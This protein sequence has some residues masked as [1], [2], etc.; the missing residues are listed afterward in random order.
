MTDYPATR[1]VFEEENEH[2]NEAEKPPRRS[3]SSHEK[4]PIQRFLFKATPVFRFSPAVPEGF[5]AWDGR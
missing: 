2:Q 3:K 1:F 5:S 4:R